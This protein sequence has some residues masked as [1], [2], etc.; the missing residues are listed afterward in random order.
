VLVDA[1]VDAFIPEEY[2]ADD[3]ARIRVYQT[4]A[5][6]KTEAEG[7]E[8][9]ADLKDIYGSVP[10]TV[11]NLIRIAVMRE[12]A[13]KVAAESVTVKQSGAYLTFCDN[14]VW[15]DNRLMDRVTE[16]KKECMMTVS[17]KPLLV[18]RT[19][20]LNLQ[21]VFKNIYNFLRNF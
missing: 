9:L 7:E 15:Q 16:W 11:S 20:G 10:E 6:L 12:N 13:R 17:E 1:D 5:D 3:S 18:F 4:I 8:C 14:S 21:E 2:I 19:K